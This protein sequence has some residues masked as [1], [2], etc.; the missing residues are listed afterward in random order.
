MVA[1]AF[2][3]SDNRVRRY[4]ETLARRGEHVDAISLR[5]EGQKSFETIN[6]VNV[7]RIQERERNEKGKLSYLARLLRFLIK[8]GVFM[9]RKHLKQPYDLIHIHSVPDF[10]VFA[11]CLPKLLGAKIILDIHDIMPEFYASKF[12]GR[13]D[14]MLFNGFLFFEKT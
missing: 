7:F 4:A 12:G 3:D 10:E 14:S 13:R 5:K 11:A 6:G 9:S 8:A 2:Y 1:Y